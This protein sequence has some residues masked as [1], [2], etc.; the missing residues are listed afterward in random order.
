MKKRKIL[1]IFVGEM[2]ILGIISEKMENFG[3]FW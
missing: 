1:V 3:H 2:I